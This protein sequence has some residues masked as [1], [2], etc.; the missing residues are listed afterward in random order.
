MSNSYISHF[1][2]LMDFTSQLKL[3]FTNTRANRADGS[4]SYDVSITN[5]GTDDLK[6]PLTLLLDPG[7][8][9]AGGVTGSVSGTG[10]QSDLWIMDLSAGLAAAG[11]KLVVGGVISNQTV[12]IV[13][14]SL[15]GTMAGAATLVKANLGAGIYAMPQENLPPTLS[16]AAPLDTTLPFD[17]SSDALPIAIAGAA[18]SANIQANDADGTLYYWQLVQAPA[19]VTLTPSGTIT[20]EAVGYSSQATLNWTPTSRDNARTEIIVRVQDSR[21]GVGTKRYTLDVAGGNTTPVIDPIGDFTLTEGQSLKLPISASDANGDPLTVTI[22]NLPAGA[23]FNAMTGVLSWKPSYDQAGQYNNITVIVSDGKTTVREQFNVTVAQGYAKP[24]LAPIPAQTLREGDAFALQLNGSMPGGLTQADGTT[25]TLT[26]SAPWLPGGATLNSETGWFAWTPGYASAGTYSMP[27][28]VTATYIPLGG[29]E[30]V[31]TRTTREI[32]MNILNANG[33]P[34]FDAVETWNILEGQP[35]RISLFA[36][37]PDNPGF[38]PQVRLTPTGPLSETTGTPATVTYQVTGLPDG[39]TFDAETLELIWTPGY[40]QAGI[41]YVNVIATDDGDGTGVPSSTQMTVPI[42]VRNANRAPDI[43][44]I[45]NAFVD[46]GAVIEIPVSAMDADGN[47]MQLTLSG[48]PRFAT[49]TQSTSANGSASGVIR[50]APG[51]G[52]RGDYVITVIARDTDQ[53]W[54]N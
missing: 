54:L 32:A 33:A 43:G 27:I 39:A 17:P 50:F 51:E 8:Y 22:N 21:G 1:T 3:D 16:V 40:S 31:T 7:R 12:T 41:Y 5:I 37:D 24:V 29:G 10:D 48:L 36:F 47:P 19:G 26:Y 52:D 42:V 11:G 30:Q 53:D 2:A 44:D 20:P 34:V 4:I 49:Y 6:G 35:L 28:T 13:P 45:S 46:K 9:F 25:I 14:A 38:E 15:F 23:S 18:W